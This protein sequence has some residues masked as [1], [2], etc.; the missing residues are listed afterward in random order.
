[1]PTRTTEN[2]GIARRERKPEWLT[3]EQFISFTSRRAGPHA[4]IRRLI[5]AFQDNLLPFQHECVHILI[6]QLLFHVGKPDWKV[7]LDVKWH[8]L[9]RISSNMRRQVDLLRESP[10]DGDCLLIFAITSSF[11]GQFEM[12]CQACARDFSGITRRWADDVSDEVR[13]CEQVSPALYWKQ[14]KF[15]GYAILCYSF[16]KL[17]DTDS[18]KMLEL[19]FLYKHKALFASAV[20]ESDCLDQPIHQVM[21][22]RV[23]GIVDAVR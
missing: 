19:I 16:G 18:L 12:D 4:Q 23:G 21:A 1:M 6:K 3:Q 7:D 22:C 9:A 2:E 13:H 14:A 5:E 17:N 10:K 11:F 15:Y 20:E 8:G